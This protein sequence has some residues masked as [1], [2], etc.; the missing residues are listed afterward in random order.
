MRKIAVGMI[1]IAAFGMGLPFALV[2][3]W[4]GFLVGMLLAVLWLWPSANGVNSRPAIIFLILASMGALGSLLGHPPA[5][6]LTSFLFLLTAWDIDYYQRTHQIFADQPAQKNRV[7]TLFYAHLKR[8]G[9]IAGLGWCLGMLAL[10]IHIQINFA[11]ALFFAFLIILGLREFVRY[12][13]QL[14]FSQHD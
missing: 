3:H 12:L 14:R 1:L 7:N 4:W 6:Q 10:N 9:I 13:A 2:G 8:L 11:L 5:W